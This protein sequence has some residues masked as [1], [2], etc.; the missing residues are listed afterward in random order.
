MLALFL[1]NCSEALLAAGAVRRFGLSAPT[2]FAEVLL[3]VLLAAGLYRRLRRM[4]DR[5]WL[6]TAVRHTIW[7][8]ALTAL[9]V[10]AAGFAL[11]HQVPAATTL[12]EAMQQL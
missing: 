5:H 10:A 11:Q 12:S 3:D 4:P 7:P 8:F 9:F 1:T 6:G 2:L